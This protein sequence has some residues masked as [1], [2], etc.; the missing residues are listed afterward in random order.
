MVFGMVNIGHLREPGEVLNYL[1]GEWQKIRNEESSEKRQE[2]VKIT[3]GTEEKNCK[4]NM[5]RIA[6]D[7]TNKIAEYEHVLVAK[8]NDVN[9]RLGVIRR[10]M[11]ELLVQYQ[12]YHRTLNKLLANDRRVSSMEE[13][14]FQKIADEILHIQKDLPNT[15]VER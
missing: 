14:E 4:V 13:H 15:L 8:P 1:K 5:D 7:F 3:L 9:S 11:H 6:T 2:I 10:R 12:Y